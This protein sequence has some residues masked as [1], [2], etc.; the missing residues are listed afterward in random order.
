M[1]IRLSGDASLHTEPAHAIRHVALDPDAYGPGGYSEPTGADR[2]HTIYF[3]DE[4]RP[5]VDGYALVSE[6]LPR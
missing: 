2:E 6:Y 3:V 5:D 4:A 1:T